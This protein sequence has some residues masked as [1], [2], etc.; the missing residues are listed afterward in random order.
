VVN[1]LDTPVNIF[2]FSLWNNSLD[3]SP[4]L[5][6]F[7]SKAFFFGVVHPVPQA[8]ELDAMLERYWPNLHLWL[9]RFWRSGFLA[10]IAHLD[11][12]DSS[13]NNC[14]AS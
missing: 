14:G 6:C 7:Q 9:W 1:E 8:T 3:V 11:D 4:K 12:Q 10:A 13:E 2:G 5:K